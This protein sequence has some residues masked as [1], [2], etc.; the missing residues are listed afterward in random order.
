M[1]GSRVIRECEPYSYIAQ[2]GDRV[3][4]RQYELECL[5]GCTIKRKVG[6]LCLALQ[7][8]T[9]VCCPDC[10]KILNETPTQI[11]K[12]IGRPR[13]S[14]TP[15]E[16]IAGVTVVSRCPLSRD[17]R[18]R[19][20][21]KCG[22]GKSIR[23]ETHLI[24]NAVLRGYTLSCFKCRGRKTKAEHLKIYEAT[25][26][27]QGTII[28][29]SKVTREHIR[30]KGDRPFKVYSLECGCG[31]TIWRTVGHL[32]RSQKTGSRI[33]C[34]SCRHPELAISLKAGDIV[35]GSTVICELENYEYR[36]RYRRKFELK[37]H[38]GRVFHRRLIKIE[39]TLKSGSPLQCRRCIATKSKSHYHRAKH[40]AKKDRIRESIAAKYYRY[41]SIWSGIVI[42]T[43]TEDI[44]EEVG[45][46]LDNE[47]P[48]RDFFSL[49]D[50][51]PLIA[52]PICLARRVDEDP[53]DE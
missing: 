16:V 23:R 36:S 34:F 50:G 13:I 31:I 43:M 38:C 27:D 6:T 35:S 5:C 18:I 45:I 52:S 28:G 20:N 42:Q 46:R 51:E 25:H 11:T 41:G 21:L 4:L 14:Y 12:T 30:I 3:T 9:V 15:G 33:A 8:K 7:T 39:S 19:Y 29:G 24:R 1:Q 44:A 26:F 32:L 17:R 47:I 22:C 48:H 40:K 10:R 37:C 2:D 53:E 49:Y